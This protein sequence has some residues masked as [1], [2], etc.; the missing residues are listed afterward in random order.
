MTAALPS[1]QTEKR[2]LPITGLIFLAAVVFSALFLWVNTLN[3]NWLSPRF[4]PAGDTI[5]GIMQRLFI[6]IP[7][8]LLSIWRPKEMGFQVGRIA[9]HWRMLALMLAANVGIVGGYVLLSGGTPYS[10]LGMLINEVVTV[11]LAEEL[12][13]RGAVFAGLLALL[14]RVHPEE[15]AALLA[16]WFSGICFGLLHANNALYG[17]PLAFVALQTLNATVWGVVYG[18]ARAKTGSIYPPLI[19]HAAMNLAVVL[20]G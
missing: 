9:K 13:W 19:F 7:V 2:S 10:G 16:G 3:Y 14:R 17:Y 11:P 1:V 12:M 4:E 15:T 20:L 6:L 8:A 5:W 18:I